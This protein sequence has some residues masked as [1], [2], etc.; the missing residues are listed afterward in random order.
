MNGVQQKSNFVRF[1]AGPVKYFKIIGI[2]LQPPETLRIKCSRFITVASIFL[3]LAHQIGYLLTPGRTF[4]EQSA[5]VALMNYTTV[6]FGKILFL[7]YN[8]HLLLKSHGQLKAIHPSVELERQYKLEHH[9]LFYARVEILLYRFFK[10]ILIIYLVYPIVQSFYDLWSTGVYTYLMPALY[11]YPV[12]VEESLL[13]YLFYVS[14]QSFSSY[15]AGTI[16]L[17]ADL[18]LFSSVS[19]LLLHLELIAQ[20]ILELQPAESDSLGALKVII[21][22]HQRIFMLAHDVNAIFAASIIFSLTSSS[23]I[24]CFSAYQLLGDVSFIF[25]LKVLL[26]LCYEMKQ[27]V[28][29]CY[30]GDRLMESSLN[31]FN[32][33]YAHNW[34]DGSPAY[35]RLVLIMMIR[36]YRPIFLNVAGI[37]D[38]TLITLKQ[39]LSASY[40][41]FAVLKTA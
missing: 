32:V 15:C 31:L 37:A 2:C 22:Y 9:L 1:T 23:F 13:V 6:S 27:V 5:A 12:R 39:V 17:S 25:A 19:Q 10:Y 14:F 20:R 3:M 38:V 21:E 35:K 40:Q 26:L 41:I 8:R 16:I 33:V 11:W 30:Y 29:T 18:C 7:I 34:P 4:A 24:L 28:I 36:T